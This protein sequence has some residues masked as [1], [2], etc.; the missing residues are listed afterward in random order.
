MAK[1]INS[2]PLTPKE[3]FDRLERT[4]ILR[5]YGIKDLKRYLEKLK[6]NIKV[7]EDAIAKENAEIKKTKGMIK[8]LQKD[9]EEADKIKKR[10]GYRV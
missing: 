4:K 8:V 9:I 5:G 3:E 10:I 6:S 2:S 7:F 1:K